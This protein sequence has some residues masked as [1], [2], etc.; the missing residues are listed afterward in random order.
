MRY[1]AAGMVVGATFQKELK[2]ALFCCFTLRELKL[3][4]FSCYTELSSFD[5]QA[6]IAFGDIERRWTEIINGPE[7]NILEDNSFQN[8]TTIKNGGK[9]ALSIAV[10]GKAKNELDLKK[11]SD[12]YRIRDG[13]FKEDKGDSSKIVIPQ[14]SNRNVLFSSGPAAAAIVNGS[15]SD[16][17]IFN[18]EEK[19]IQIETD[20]QPS[21]RFAQTSIA[22]STMS[23]ALDTEAASDFL[24]T[25]PNDPK[26]LD[27]LNNICSIFPV[28]SNLLTSPSNTSNTTITEG[29]ETISTGSNTTLH[30]PF[31]TLNPS[32]ISSIS[33]EDLLSALDGATA[34]VFP[35]NSGQEPEPVAFLP[36]EPPPNIS[37]VDTLRSFVST[38]AAQQGISN[39]ESELH[40]SITLPL[41]ILIILR[42]QVALLSAFL[43]KNIEHHD[44]MLGNDRSPSNE[45]LYASSLVKKPKQ[46]QEKIP[47]LT[48]HLASKLTLKFPEMANRSKCD[49]KN[50]LHK[51][52]ML[53]LDVIMGTLLQSPN[54][55]R[56]WNSL[57]S[58][59]TEILSS[60]VITVGQ[61]TEDGIARG[62]GESVSLV[63]DAL[64]NPLNCPSRGADP[65]TNNPNG[66][67]GKKS[68][69]KKKKKV[70]R[71]F[72]CLNHL[73]LLIVR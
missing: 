40:N 33:G 56:Q 10:G 43:D 62:Y 29:A 3:P 60:L 50:L 17:Q 27:L 32:Y 41:Y 14:N 2:P 39:Q 22:K 5:W 31:I 48:N 52:L 73:A 51:F 55:E 35:Q 7:S 63:H 45:V 42:F 53:P 64:V 18:E 21:T 20:A 46:V 4:R 59:S 26:V 70:R 69:R 54:I 9:T 37:V 13:S 16:K 24:T 12:A 25:Y 6:R 65:F 30:S 28:S 8:T 47:I 19:L 68:K 67:A 36:S 23:P 1:T 71:N 72:R 57:Q 38:M 66:T 34:T 58:I 61:G 49:K 15:T 11:E 44:G